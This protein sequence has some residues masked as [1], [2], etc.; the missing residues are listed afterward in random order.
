MY[1]W[2]LVL[3]LGVILIAIIAGVVIYESHRRRR[4]MELRG[5]AL[6]GDPKVDPRSANE[7]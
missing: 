6:P 7:P 2:A 4:E 5:F 1:T 3:V